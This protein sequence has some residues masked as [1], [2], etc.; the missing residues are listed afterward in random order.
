MIPGHRPSTPRGRGVWRTT[1]VPPCGRAG[2]QVPW[3][4]LRGVIGPAARGSLDLADGRDLVV[5]PS[6]ACQWKE[7]LDQR[8]EAGRG[9]VAEPAYPKWTPTQ[10]RSPP[11]PR[12][13]RRSDSRRPPSRSGSPCRGAHAE[14][15]TPPR[16][17]G[18]EPGGR[19]PRRSCG[20]FRARCG[21]KTRPS[22]GEGGV[23]GRALELPERARST[24]PKSAEGWGTA[25]SGRPRRAARASPRPRSAVYPRAPVRRPRTDRGLAAPRRRR[26]RLLE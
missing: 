20:P 8:E 18:R 7:R 13:R 5:A 24:S 12:A 15:R 11:R 1:I 14:A 19:P 6:L 10:T 23:R 25:R 21:R 9:L 16:G 4:D 26:D 22:R 3:S 17:C 2:L